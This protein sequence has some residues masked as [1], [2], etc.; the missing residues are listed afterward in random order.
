MN[1]SLLLPLLSAGILLGLAVLFRRSGMPED[2]F[3][4]VSFLVFGIVLGLASAF[5]WPQDL[6]VYLNVL[7]AAAGDGIYHT[8]I[9]VIGNPNSDQA[10][11]TIPW[12]FRVPLVYA[13][14]SPMLYGVIGLAIQ[15]IHSQLR[16]R[17]PG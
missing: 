9:T 16:K 11:F 6:S 5:L 14:I 10:H 7:G 13:W 4:L 8:A 15:L 12:L 1:S 3:V 17:K 2:R